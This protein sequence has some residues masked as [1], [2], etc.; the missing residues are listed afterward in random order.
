MTQYA[1]TLDNR[2][3]RRDADRVWEAPPEAEMN[4]HSI[5]SE[6]LQI[7]SRGDGVFRLLM[8]GWWGDFVVIGTTARYIAGSVEL[9]DVDATE[10]LAAQLI[11]L[12]F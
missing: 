4:A 10:A 11:A 3:A 9:P 7:E 1:D 2:R 8:R 12:G 6:V 5:S